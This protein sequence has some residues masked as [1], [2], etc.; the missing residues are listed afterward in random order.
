MKVNLKKTKVILFNPRKRGI[1]FLPEVRLDGELL[2]VVDQLRLVGFVISDDLSWKKNTESLVSRAFAKVWIIRRLKAMGASKHVLK[3]VFF[4]HIRAILE[5]GVPA[6]NGAITDSEVRKLE[7]VQKVVL[8]LIYGRNKSYAKLL[9]EAKVENLQQRR[10]RL[11]LKFA[12]KALKH[13]KFS[14]WFKQE[15]L[16][17]PNSKAKYV[18]CVTRHKRLNN[19]PIPYFTRLLNLNNCKP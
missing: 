14:N 13:P 2:E 1:D 16:G 17:Q 12:Q 5:F 7:F 10:E 4:Q 18:E 3:L 15:N 9:L 19:S 11:C 6:W 8:R